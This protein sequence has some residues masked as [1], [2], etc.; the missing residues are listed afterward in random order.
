M[1]RDG[2][3]VYEVEDRKP[4]LLFFFKL[5]WRKFSQIVRLNL[6]L[7]VQMI[8]LLVFLYVYLVG[9]KTPTATEKIYAPLYGISQI[10]PSAELT[11]LMDM[12][13]IQMGIPIFPPAI[14][15]LLI[16]LSVIGLGCGELVANA[17]HGIF[18]WY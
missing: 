16:V 5:L 9:Y 15:I 18:I 13:S 1:N 17:L 6:L 10:T 7:L 2:K 8:P 14:L 12:Q 3:G 4:T 11:A